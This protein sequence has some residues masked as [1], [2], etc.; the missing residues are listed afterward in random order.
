[1]RK[2]FVYAALLSLLG[3]VPAAAE[4]VF[5]P[6]IG[7]TAIDG[8]NL[9]TEIW[10]TNTEGVERAVMASFLRDGMGEWET[11]HTFAVQPGGRM[12]ERQ[13]HP[14]EIGL[15]AV[16]AGAD[17]VSAWIVDGRQGYVSEVPVIAAQ[18]AYVAGAEPSFDLRADYDRLW[19]GAA[20]LGETQA[21][22][23]ATLLG[24]D[25]RE[26]A[27]I[28]FEVAPRALARE[29]ATAWLGGRRVTGGQ[30]RC[31]QAFYPITATADVAT[32]QVN[33]EKDTGPNGT[34]DKWIDLAKQT[35]NTY[36]AK[37]EGEFHEATK[38]DPKE[39]FCARAA[40]QLKIAK[41]V[42][43]WDVVVGPWDSKRPSGIHNLGYF[44][45]ERYRSGVIGNVNALG[46]GRE[47]VKIMQNYSM[48]KFSNTNAKGS[49]LMQRNVKYHVV[50]TFDAANKVAT[51]QLLQGQTPIKT[52]TA[53]TRPGNGQTLLVTPYG[54]GGLDKLAMVLEFG[55]YLANGGHPEVATIGWRYSDFS[56]RM[57]PK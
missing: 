36:F 12:L 7:A 43:E 10:I 30:I 28:P 47:L 21:S 5:V 34:C 44:F 23:E 17:T 35:D 54:R 46:P 39:I 26:L 50:Y 3:V 52:L 33:F 55:N 1:M 2:T 20:N 32:G 49:Y 29:D 6:V 57:T 16:E 48:P 40:S 42:F 53:E 9:P 31:D 11:A 37:V 38:A 24:A 14:G 22:C 4:R 41:A 18:D 56:I 25:D 27:R 13:A 15:V 8:R 19:I 51:M 45:G